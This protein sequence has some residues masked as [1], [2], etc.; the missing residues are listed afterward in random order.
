[1]ARGMVQ[2]TNSPLHVLTTCSRVTGLS[3]LRRIEIRVSYKDFCFYSEFT[4]NF[5]KNPGFRCPVS[6]L[7]V[8]IHAMPWHCCMRSNPSAARCYRQPPTN[9]YPG[10]IGAGSHKTWWPT[11][12]QMWG[13][14]KS[15][16]GLIVNVETILNTI[17]IGIINPYCKQNSNQDLLWF[18]D[19]H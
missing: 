12:L 9:A 14:N 6:V 11:G 7:A 1:M 5:K 18:F 13:T 17:I 8:I 4:S 15:T 19:F 16:W 2:M 10:A 3:K